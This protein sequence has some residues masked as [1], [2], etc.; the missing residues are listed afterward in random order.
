MPKESQVVSFTLIR[1][2]TEKFKWTDPITGETRT[3]FNPPENAGFKERVPFFI[4]FI[5][6]EGKVVSGMVTCIA[7]YPNRLQRLVKFVESGE[8]RI[9]HD[10]LVI[11]ID[12]THFLT[13]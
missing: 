1:M 5:T 2:Y 3:G 10:Y 11:E 6:E 13:H 12:G 9:A 4:R 8:K 7:V